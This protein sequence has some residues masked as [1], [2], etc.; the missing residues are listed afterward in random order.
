M[1]KVPL[2]K[3]SHVKC[4]KCN[5]VENDGWNE[6]NDAVCVRRRLVGVCLCEQFKLVHYIFVVVERR[7]RFDVTSDGWVRRPLHS[8]STMDGYE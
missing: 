5:D 6:L 1:L 4:R 7:R 3:V 2:L 8:D